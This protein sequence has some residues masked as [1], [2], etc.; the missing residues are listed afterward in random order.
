VLANRPPL[1]CVVWT[2]VLARGLFLASPWIESA[3]AFIGLLVAGSL[4]AALTTPAQAMLIERA[5]PAAERGRALGLVRMVAA[6]LGIGLVLVGGAAVGGTGYR[7]VFPLAALAGMAGSLVLSAMPVPHEAARGAEPR[8]GL[9]DAWVAVRDDADFRRLLGA[10]FV[11]GTG[12]WIQMP[13]NPLVVADV[14]GAT[15]TQVGALAACGSL[16]TLAGSAYWGRRVDRTGS[17]RTLGVVYAV[18]A[19]AAVAYLVARRPWMLVPT[20]VLDALMHSGLDLVWVLAVID[21]AGRRRTA[22]YMAVA[23]VLTGIRG[24]LAPLLGAALI[25]GFGV[26]AVYVVSASAMAAAA[27][28]VGRQLRRGERAPAEARPAPA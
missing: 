9:R 19:A 26:H 5:Y 4:L 22:Q 17:V 21:V 18:G 14:V 6:T 11:F 13:A 8:A 25:E 7:W 27:W 3:W 23:G 10:A 28:L 24:I 20:S 2:T 16:A 1:Q 12:V 15:T